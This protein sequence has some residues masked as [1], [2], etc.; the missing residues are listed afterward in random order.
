[1]R[2]STKPAVRRFA[3]NTRGNVAIL[4]G[5]AI[6]PIVLGVGVAVDYG[7]AL[8]V[9]ERMVSAADAAALAIGSWT[10][11]TEAELKVK[12]QQYFDAN[13]P[14]ATLGSV[15]A[16]NV[17]FVGN[18]INVDVSGSV[19]TTFMKL[20]NIDAVDVG[21]NAVIT[22]RQR[23][24]EVALV[25]DTTGSMGRGS[26]MTS[27]KTAGKSM[28]KTLFGDKATSED[29]KIA[30]V[31]F[32]GA[33]NIGT[34]KL[35]SGWLDK[36]SHPNTSNIA[37]EDHKFSNGQSI[38]QLFDDL[39]S[40][41]WG[42]CV[43][44]RAG[45][46]ELTDDA[47]SSTNSK[48]APYF[49][50]DEPDDDHDNGNNYTNDYI[51]DGNC[52]TNNESKRK[53]NKCQRY[54]GKYNNAQPSS[55]GPNYNCPNNSITALTNVKSTVNTA[56]DA[57]SP[58]G[59]TVIPAGLLWG[60]RVLS[61]GEPF[62]EGAA[63]DSDKWIKAIV[64]LTDGE[65]YVDQGDNGHNNSNYNAFGFA[66]KGH[67]GSKSGS[68]AHAELNAKTTA[69]CAAI[70]AQGIRVYTIGFQVYDSTT[71][72]MLK[73]CATEPAMAYLSPTSSALTA[74]FDSIAQGLSDLRIA[75]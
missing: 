2:N 56:I 47:P 21:A 69:V 70:K 60:W 53:P 40:T 18:D 51:S 28:V 39:Q 61:P 72:N 48:F 63:Y 66:K 12:G 38:L 15:G 36:A 35:D 45:A 46:Y 50:P 71:I 67:L 27:M 19:P 68:G 37:K 4:F 7:R 5:L 13:Y 55:G 44:E 41:S 64:L 20:A 24:I 14:A 52:G 30:V 62:T 10:G 16:L 3:R 6:I 65:N 9:R 42:G 73:T 57:L 75:Q 22:V 11:L 74:I 31:P 25:L 58:K 33:V 1:M 32:S 26:K 17:T 34:D 23:N 49:A 54:T 8:I 59:N 29:V 43:R